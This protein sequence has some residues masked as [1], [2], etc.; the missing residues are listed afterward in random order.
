VR[1]LTLTSFALL[2]LATGGCGGGESKDEKD[3]KSTVNGLY[4]AVARKDA[5]KFCGYLTA[6]QRNSL[7]R[8]GSRGA[9]RQSCP[10]VI[11][12]I[13]TFSKTGAGRNRKVTK[14]QVDG[15][16]AKAEVKLAN[17]KGVV[18]LAKENGEWKVSNFS[19]KKL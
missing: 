5:P 11:R 19:L 3:V 14:V 9:N 15:D 17:R 16:T 10:Q 6:K 18:G 1:R 7:V 8:V 13:F 2:A 4:D 12:Y